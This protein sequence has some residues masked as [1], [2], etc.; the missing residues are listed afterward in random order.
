MIPSPL[1][2]MFMGTPEFAVASL[3]TLVENQAASDLYRVVAVITATD[4]PQGRG[5]KIAHSPVKEYALSQGI[6]VLQPPNLKSPA[7]LEELRSYRADLQVVV[8]FRMLPEVVWNMPRVGTFNLHASYL[9]QYRGAAPINWAIIN[10]ETE[11]GVTTFMIRHEI[12][13]GNILFQEREPIH[14][15][16]TVGTLYERLMQKGG[17]LVLRTVRAIAQNNYYLI[18]Q[19]EVG[20]LKEAP[21]LQRETCRI[22]WHQPAEVIRNFVRGLSPYPAA[23]TMLGD[24]QC[25]LFKV[26]DT[27][28]SSETLLP[29]EYVTD[30]KTYLHIQTQG[31][32]LAVEDLQPEGKRRLTIDEFLRGNSL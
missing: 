4:K 20:E 7:F 27:G 12:D 9:P 17:T 14:P 22:D 30:N 13:T 31:T 16:D 24:K 6:P 23:W 29:G 2:I 25:K 32:L 1:R 15:D 8:A 26:T 19:E 18:P 11:T 5:R 28:K 3:Q 10:G 21:K